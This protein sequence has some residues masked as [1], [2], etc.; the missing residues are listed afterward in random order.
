MRR[1]LVGLSYK[2]FFILILQIPPLIAQPTAWTQV[3][4]TKDGVV[5]MCWGEN[6]NIIILDSHVGIFSS[7]DRGGIWNLLQENLF[8]SSLFSL[9]RN[10]KGMLFSSGSGYRARSSDNG[11]SWEY[12]LYSSYVSNTPVV[13]TPNDYLFVGNWR[14]KGNYPGGI[15]RS[16]NDGAVWSQLHLNEDI[17][18]LV[19]DPLGNIYAFTAYNGARVSNDYGETW[20]NIIIPPFSSIISGKND[21]LFAGSL[22]GI[23]VSSDNGKSWTSVGFVDLTVRA[24]LIDSKGFV[25]AATNNGM[26]K[27]S[28]DGNTWIEIN[29]G[30]T[31]LNI[32]YATITPDDYI[33]IGTLWK[34]VFKSTGPVTEIERGSFAE[35]PR[36]FLLAQNY[37]NPFNPSTRIEFTLAQPTD[38]VLKVYNLLGQEMAT[39]VDAKLQAGK[40]HFEWNGRN[41]YNVSVSTGVYFY[42]LSAGSFV[43]TKKM[44]LMK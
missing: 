2:V 18:R 27:S 26:F 7:P 31:D 21:K 33:F 38:V 12:V 41:N 4:Q 37:P 30:L 40:H 34:G 36:S 44:V 10:S 11:S 9:T 15:D 42:R 19:T 3:Y 43:E 39:L 1:E 8:K 32:L 29:S 35:P 14:Y 24:I 13:V 23:Y 5:G 16:T 28:N 6:K 22:T 20:S 17:Q 25:Y